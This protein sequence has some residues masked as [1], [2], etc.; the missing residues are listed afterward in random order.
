MKQ[1]EPSLKLGG[2][3]EARQ[4][5]EGVNE[6]AASA[7]LRPRQQQ[8]QGGFSVR[9]KLK[10]GGLGGCRKEEGRREGEEQLGFFWPQP[11]LHVTR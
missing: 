7:K 2:C 4:G 3:Q 6:L 10:L 5:T 1:A 9:P 11:L 8:C